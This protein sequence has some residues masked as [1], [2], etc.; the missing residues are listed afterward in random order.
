[1]N[2]YPNNY[3][4]ASAGQVAQCPDCGRQFSGNVPPLCPQCERPFTDAER[5][6]RQVS[7]QGLA[8][9]ALAGSRPT[10]A[11]WGDGYGNSSPPPG[12]QRARSWRLV[13]RWALGGRAIGSGRGRCLCG[14]DGEDDRRPIDIV[15]PV[16][17]LAAGPGHWFR[18]F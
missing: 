13:R 14:L 9:A 2:E 8:D 3:H 12:T 1:M 6:I 18:R 10:S 5:G 15:Y 11:Q 4:D 17:A 16:R 7:T